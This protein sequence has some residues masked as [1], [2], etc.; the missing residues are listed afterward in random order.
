MGVRPSNQLGISGG[1]GW[2]APG[3]NAFGFYGDT[4]GIYRRRRFNGKYF[5]ERARFY[6]P[7]NPRSFAQQSRREVFASGVVL[8]QALTDFEKASYNLRARRLHM[9][10]FNLHQ[11]EYLQAYA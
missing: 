9:S 8:W 4:C 10:G 5:P 1:F 6:R 2:I 7:T 11:R 3:L